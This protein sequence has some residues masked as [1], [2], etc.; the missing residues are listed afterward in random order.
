MKLDFYL[1]RIGSNIYTTTFSIISSTSLTSA[2]S[3]LGTGSPTG[4]N[5]PLLSQFYIE[6][7]LMEIVER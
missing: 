4:K 5:Y 1:S 7:T 6:H 2:L 3:L